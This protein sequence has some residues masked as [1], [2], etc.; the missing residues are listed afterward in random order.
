MKTVVIGLG[1]PFLS[2][3]SIGPRVVRNLV[4]EGADGVRFV[5]LHAGGLLLLEELEGAEQAIIVDAMLD[6]GR[7]A[8]TVLV[9]DIGIAANNACCSHDCDLPQTLSIGQALGMKLPTP[10]NIV[11]VAVVAADVISFDEKLTPAV[12]AALPEACQIIRTLI[13]GG[14]DGKIR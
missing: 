7:P 9:G 1:S 14:T 11:L 3:D 8:G 4:A 6:A 5:E 2:D 10:D 13:K 12:E